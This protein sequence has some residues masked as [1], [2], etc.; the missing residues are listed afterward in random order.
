MRT[1]SGNWACGDAV[2]LA[3]DAALLNHASKAGNLCMRCG[4]AKDSI[5]KTLREPPMMPPCWTKPPGRLAEHGFA[6]ARRIAVM[7]VIS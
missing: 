1:N 7:R 3:R 4:D 6:A 2:R 5:K